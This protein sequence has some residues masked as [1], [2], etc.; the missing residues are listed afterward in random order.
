MTRIRLQQSAVDSTASAL[1]EA[2]DELTDGTASDVLSRIDEV[3]DLSFPLLDSLS[4]NSVTIGSAIGACLVLILAWVVSRIV[5]AV[6]HRAMKRRGID[7]PG[8]VGATDRLL[9]YL[10]MI[11]GLGVAIEVLGFDLT[12]LF[13]AGAVVA[14]GL[15]FAMQNILQNFVSGFILLIERSIK[16]ADVIEVEGK[17][18][19]VEEM[20]VRSTIV[21]TWDEEQLIIPNTTLVQSTVKNFTFRD[22]LYRLRA[23]VGVAYDTDL[24]R[25][26]EV[27]LEAASKMAGRSELRDPVVLLTQFGDNSINFNVSAWIENIWTSRANRSDLHFQIWRALKEAG[28][29]IAFPQLDVHL[30]PAIEEV[31]GGGRRGGR[32][33]SP[34]AR[35]DDRAASDPPNPDEGKKGGSPADEEG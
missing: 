8:T 15:G 16:P 4:S 30:D 7:D 21:R 27:L 9:H 17:V 24:D 23:D 5:R 33:R 2:A 11:L 13:A 6:V 19:K 1:M 26:R 35:E 12:A 34:G 28:I 18:V 22:D 31:L 20:G 14:V 3:L 25:A 10:I 32:D 29:T